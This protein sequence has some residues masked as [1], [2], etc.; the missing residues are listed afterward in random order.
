MKDEK[1]NVVSKNQLQR[2]PIYLELL[3]KMKN[4]GQVCVSSQTMANFLSLSEEAVK[5]DFALVSRNPGRPNTGRD[6]GELIED[7]E[8]FL[9]YNDATS[10]VLIGVGHLGRAFLNYAGFS[11]YGIKI[12]AAFDN[13]PYVI[14]Q[15][16]NEIQVFPVDKMANLIPRLNAHIG[17]ITVPEDH[18]QAVAD[19]L[20]KC[21]IKAIWNFAPAHLILPEDI[22]IQNVNLA[23]SLAVLSH[24]L[25][26]R[27]KKEG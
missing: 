5:K 8:S 23:S 15:K 12:L 20:V 11:E 10:A 3:R 18:A 27:Y 9:G 22:I 13:N 21:G 16:I 7:L 25:T 14:D 4:D 19:L 6:I 26:Q 17:I 24:E 1:I 2:F